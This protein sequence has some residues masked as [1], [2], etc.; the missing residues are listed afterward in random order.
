MSLH[1]ILTYI[2]TG[3][4]SLNTRLMDLSIAMDVWRGAQYLGMDILLND[5]EARMSDMC[6]SYKG[7]D[8]ACRRRSARVF[9]FAL[10][11]DVNSTKLQALSRPVVI[12]HFGD[13]WDEEIGQL[14]YDQQKSLLTDLCTRTTAE[15]ATSAFTGICRL[16]SRLANERQPW[17]D[18][19]RAMLLPLQDRV[20]YIIRTNLSELVISPAFVALIDGVGFAYDVLEKLLELVVVSLTESTAPA[21]YEVLV[22]KVLLREDGLHVDA[23]AR[24]EDARKAIIEYLRKRWINARSANAFNALENWCLKE[25][26]DGQSGTAYQF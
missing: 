17:A 14:S 12:N 24:V 2:Y 6:H 18:H 20:T 22:G 7:C 4:L 3:T 8:R 16:R 1:Y 25:L 13:A 5:V 15:T 23:R 11:S 10:A 26:S 19:I 9:A 21:T